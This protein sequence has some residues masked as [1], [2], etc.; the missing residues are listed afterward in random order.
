MAQRISRAKQSIKTS[1]V[2]VRDAGAAASWPRGSARVTAR[3]LSDLQRGLRGQL[4]HRARQRPICP[5]EA[6]RLTR[7]LHAARCPTT[8]E[9][10]G[11]L[12][13]MLLTDARRA[14]RTGPAGEIDPARRAGSSAVGP[15]RDRRGRRARSARRCRRGASAR[16]SCRPR[17]R[18]CTTRRRAPRRPTGR[19]SWRCTACSMRMSD[20]PMVALNHAIATAMVDGPAAGLAAA[21]R[22]RRGP[23]PRGP[24]PPRRRARALLERAGDR[25]GAIAC[26]RRAAERTASIAERNYLLMQAA[27]L[28]D[29]EGKSRQRRRLRL[30]GEGANHGASTPR[31]STMSHAETLQSVRHPRRDPT[32]RPRRSSAASAPS[33]PAWSRSSRSPP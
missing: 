20:N 32:R 33:P 6:M 8:R 7:L 27:R 19:R 5:S 26:Y 21:R 4:G 11:L 14:A 2:P 12:A 16:T 15:G 1:G 30:P 31:R 28:R 17:S 22:A 9:V 29:V 18:P 3:P 24:P 13:L 25:D 23:A 10:A